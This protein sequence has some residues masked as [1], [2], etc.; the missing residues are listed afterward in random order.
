MTTAA[1]L[2]KP[3]SLDFMEKCLRGTQ[4]LF[5]L[6]GGEALRWLAHAKGL[7]DLDEDELMTEQMQLHSRLHS[8]M[9]ISH[10]L[11]HLCISAWPHLGHVS[12]FFLSFLHL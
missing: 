9:V 7:H 3:V 2:M 4:G 11:S 8:C 1:Q 6:V 12:S 10:H 5:Q